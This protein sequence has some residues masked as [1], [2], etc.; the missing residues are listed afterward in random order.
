MTESSPGA[1]SHAPSSRLPSASWL[2]GLVLIVSLLVAGWGFLRDHW[3]EADSQRDNALVVGTERLLSALKDVETGQRGFIITGKDQYLEPYNWGL[4]AVGPALHSIDVLGGEATALSGMVADR[5]QEAAEGIAIYRSQGPEAGAARI[6]TGTGKALMDRV[7]A[8]V[9]RLQLSADQRLAGLA[10]HRRFNDV[11]RLLSLAGLVLAGAALAGVALRRRREQRASQAL[12]NGVLDNAPVGLGF[13]DRTLRVRHVN[14]ALAGMSAQALDG[15][16]AHLWEIVPQLRSTLEPRLDT[17]RRAGEAAAKIDVETAAPAKD[18]GTNFYQASFYP[19]PPDG[20]SGVSQDIGMVVADI[21]A[22][23]RAEQR[24]QESEERLR[25]LIEAT[26][27][28]IWTADPTGAFDKPQPYWSRFTGQSPQEAL[29][30]GRLERVHPEDLAVMQ[31]AWRTGLEA[32]A[33]IVTE[34]RLRRADGEWRYMALSAAPVLNDDGSIREWVGSHT[35][36]TERKEAELMLSAAKH[37]AEAANRAKSSFLAN[38]SHELR[39]PLSAVIGYSEMLEE[40]VEDLGETAILTDLGKIKS[41]ARHLLSLIND[42]LDLSK[43]EANKMDIYAETIDIEPFIRDVASTVHALI[44]KKSNQLDIRL[45]DELGTM[46]SDSVKL[47]QC[48]F[49]LLSNAAKF[50]ENGRI[51]LRV[52]RDTR[53]DGDWIAFEVADTGIGMTS[54]Q[55]QRLFERFAQADETTTRR[56]GGTGLGLALSRGFS[57]LLGGDITVDSAEGRGTCF[58]MAVPAIMPTRQLDDDIQVTDVDTPPPEA[59]RELVLVI[60]DE[61]SQRDLMSRFLERQRFDVRTASDGS[62]GIA[63]ARS[64]K[65]RAILLDVMMPHMDGW[66]V[67]KTLKADPELARIPVVLVTFVADVGLGSAMGAVDHLA[68]PIDW[69][70]LKTLMDR[71]RDAEGDVLVVDDDEDMRARL[72]TI[73]ERD[74]WTVQEASNGAEALE[75]VLVA[76]PRVILLDLTM[77]V[78]DGFAFLGRLR[79]TPGREDTP[80]VVLSARDITADERA[81]LAEADRILK[82]GDTSM[83]A[84][85]GEIRAL[86]DR[87]HEPRTQQR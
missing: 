33:P 51:E 27:A 13:F 36:I 68:K 49:N 65:P 78:M 73:L 77:P 28:I 80:V 87:G 22:R 47:R 35:D 17:V 39:T 8:E 4:G 67:L 48:L 56:F 32:R 29:G 85:K 71:F 70:K 86:Q 76:A 37:A 41:N 1:G 6:Q 23:K 84:L 44:A 34:H 9:G 5:L 60:D 42:V 24:T 26:A 15:G 69:Q 66:S 19:L 75:H 50:T 79:E 18:G 20:R 58:T 40:E 12:L 64:L 45:G 3:L 14:Q 74:G 72:R 61:A 21:T 38:M 30:W 7:R 2:A 59:R 52:R 54:D 16:P 46:R 10:Q 11:L 31:D 57:R 25:T 55:L 53:P 82:K 63:M 83:Q 62:T 81:A 43:I